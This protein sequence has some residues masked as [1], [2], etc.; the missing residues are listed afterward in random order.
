MDNIYMTKDWNTSMDQQSHSEQDTPQT[1]KWGWLPII[2][3]LYY[4]AGVII[5][6]D[7]SNG[8]NNNFSRISCR[9][10][11]EII[12]NQTMLGWLDLLT[13]TSFLLPPFILYSNLNLISVPR[14]WAEMLMS[15]LWAC[16]QCI[17]KIAFSALHHYCLFNWCTGA[18]SQTWHVGSGWGCLWSR[19]PITIGL[20]GGNF[21][22]GGES[23]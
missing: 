18:S 20:G 14:R 6:G 7:S 10:Q 11:N 22:Q 5:H 8:S 17:N 23:F 4:G 15:P 12:I 1:P 16:G 13:C 9:T 19:S 3:K 21:S 2:M